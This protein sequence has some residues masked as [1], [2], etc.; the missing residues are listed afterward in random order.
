MLKHQRAFLSSCTRAMLV[1]THSYNHLHK[2]INDIQKGK[3]FAEGQRHVQKGRNKALAADLRLA[4][5]AG[6]RGQCGRQS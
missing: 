3:S 2:G 6:G 1:I 4:F 5:Q